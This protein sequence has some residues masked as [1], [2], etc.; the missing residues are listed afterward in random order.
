MAKH[1]IL[2]S[3][4]LPRI[5]DIPVQVVHCQSGVWFEASFSLDPEVSA[6]DVALTEQQDS[7]IRNK[8]NAQP[9]L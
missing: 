4:S 2:D 8:F 1:I 3:M 5:L 7:C 9:T 6:V